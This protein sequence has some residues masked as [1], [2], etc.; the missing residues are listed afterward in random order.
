M[1]KLFII[2]IVAIIILVGLYIYLYIQEVNNHT[3]FNSW[4]KKCF[5][6]GGLTTLMELGSYSNQYECIKDG[7][8]INHI[9]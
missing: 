5:E 3:E 8:I 7:E 2:F 4:F 9:K 1:E 6:D